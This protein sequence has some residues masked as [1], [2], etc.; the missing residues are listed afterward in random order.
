MVLRVWYIGE[1]GDGV[2]CDGNILKKSVTPDGGIDLRL[3]FRRK[4]NGLRVAA[5]FKVEN[6]FVVPAVF[7]VADE[8][9]VGVGGEVP[10]RPQ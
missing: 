4:I 3:T 8:S 10:W 5:S 7:I 2:V 1:I 9:A 6:A